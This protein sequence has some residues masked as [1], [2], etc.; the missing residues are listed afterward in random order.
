[1]RLSRD[2]DRTIGDDSHGSSR[3]TDLLAMGF[4]CR[5]G[6]CVVFGQ[7][8]AK[9]RRPFARLQEKGG[10]ETGRGANSRPEDDETRYSTESEAR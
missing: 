4:R 8:T 9:T 10:M 3:R 6:G 5:P 2:A 1:M 7:R